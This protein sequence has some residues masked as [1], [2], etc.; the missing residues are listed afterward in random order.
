MYNVTCT[1]RCDGIGRRS[2][3]KIHRWRQ[4]TGSSPVTGTTWSQSSLCDHVFLC[5]Q[6]K[7]VIRPLPCPSVPTATRFAG[8]AVGGPPCGRL[9][10]KHQGALIF[11]LLLSKPDPLRW[12]PVWCRSMGGYFSFLTAL[13]RINGICER[14]PRKRTTKNRFCAS[15]RKGLWKSAGPS[16]CAYQKRAQ[17]VDWLS[18]PLLFEK[19]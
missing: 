17:T 6:Q 8:L 13:Y 11:L 9:F 14:H 12:A 1:G 18:A 15:A 10:Y 3:L 4:R 7:V 19:C 16:S 5:L 2:G